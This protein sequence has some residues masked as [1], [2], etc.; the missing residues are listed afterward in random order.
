MTR[1]GRRVA[2]EERGAEV[3]VLDGEGVEGSEELDARSRVA[4]L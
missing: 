3:E 2:R 1:S 4:D